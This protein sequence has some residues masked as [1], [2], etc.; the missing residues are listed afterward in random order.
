MGIFAT[1][2]SLLAT[3]ATTFSYGEEFDIQPLPQLASASV[4]STCQ[5]RSGAMW[6]NTSY[7]LFRYNG[8]ALELVHNPLP[9]HEITHDGGDRIWFP[10]SREIIE[11]D[12]RSGKT[13]LISA[14]GV[15]FSHAAIIY[16]DGSLLVGAGNT[17]YSKR[18]G[19]LDTLAFLPGEETFSALSCTAGGNL[20]AGTTSG[21]LFVLDGDN[22]S[23]KGDYS[24]KICA[25]RLLE[26]GRMA[27]GL[28]SGGAIFCNGNSLDPE[29]RVSDC[30]G[31]DLL[32]VRSFIR[33][34]DGGVWI[35]AVNGLFH[36]SADGSVR[37]VRIDGITGRPVC[38]VNCDREGNVWTGTYYNGV[39]ISHIG[40][41]PF[42]RLPYREEMGIIKGIVEDKSGTLWSLTDNYGIYKLQKGD[43][44]WTKCVGTEGIKYQG[45]FYDRVTDCIWAGVYADGIV[46]RRLSDGKTSKIHVESGGEPETIVSIVR[47]GKELY[48]GGMGG[49]YVFDPESEQRVCR[50]VGGIKSRI[51]GLAVAPDGTIWTSGEHIFRIGIDGQVAKQTKPGDRFRIYSQASCDENGRL[52]AAVPGKGVICQDG[53]STTVYDRK[54]NGL[55][56]DFTFCFLQLDS[57]HI[58]AGTR[59]GV[60]I[61]NVRDGSCRNYD[62][63]N[64]LW[65][66]SVRG[67][68]SC[69]VLK[70]GT[71]LVCGSGGI[72]GISPGSVQFEDNPG[73]GLSVDRLRIN[74][75]DVE[76]PEDRRL[77][78]SHDRNNFLFEMSTFSYTDPTAGRHFCKLEGFDREWQEI[79]PDGH[80][81]YMNIAPGKYRFTA[82][83]VIGPSQERTDG[84]SLEII[85]RPV[86]FATALAKTGFA[87]VLL[88]L[89]A[90]IFFS[91]NSRML[92]AEKLKIKEKENEERA[93]FFVNMSY[94]MRTPLNVIIGQMERF[95][96]NYGART[97]GIEDL[98]NIY[99]K[100]KQMRSMVSEF[101]D[102]ENERAEDES[103][104]I[105]TAGTVKN[106]KFLNSAIGAVERNLFS[107]DLSVKTLCD[108]LNIGKTALTEK[109]KDVCGLTPR[110]FIEDIRL[111]HAAEMLRDGNLRVAE[112]SDR[113]GFSS[114]KYFAKRFR[115]KFGKSPR[116]VNVG[117][118]A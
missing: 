36:L 99:A 6:L 71:V 117:G 26:D 87:L 83:S 17:L 58:L 22:W 25:L 23:E 94:K 37:E 113:L 66:T 95:F 96:K 5:D 92:M 105:H 3:V 15:Q 109:I 47:R 48:M 79:G 70:D 11:L 31:K 106:A 54:N 33:D 89:A 28:M 43:S 82:K 65:L 72:A 7:G 53:D 101:V 112:V 10:S 44:E 93:Q 38:S 97:A 118:R 19:N 14:D 69:T 80:A 86:W 4:Y 73:L 24:S 49:L 52:W 34:R 46:R 50:R 88:A 55:A 115:L 107:P 81:Y 2:A 51:S 100:A 85:I 42:T 27:L 39:H 30:G 116:E 78:L 98:E 111:N 21:K 67:G 62:R 74:G 57:L 16:R 90:F 12:T 35:G 75:Q 29:G 18:D 40:D 56:T 45:A 76:I 41:F 8:H 63:N 60:S 68:S 13:S 20:A 9:M 103:G 84:E 104:D 110:A 102:K 59:D 108:E 32:E 114:P 1:L 64:G 77:T 61:L 91:I